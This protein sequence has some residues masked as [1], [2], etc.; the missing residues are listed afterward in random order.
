MAGVLAGS[1]CSFMTGSTCQG[2]SAVLGRM[3]RID[4]QGDDI[5]QIRKRLNLV[6]A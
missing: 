2:K 1:G 4:R 6:G 3:N 5:E